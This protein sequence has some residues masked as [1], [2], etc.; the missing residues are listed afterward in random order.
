MTNILD[1]KHPDPAAPA[2]PAAIEFDG[3]AL[4]LDAGALIGPES[5][6]WEARGT[7]T[8]NGR[9]R[10][11]LTLTGFAIV[12]GAVSFWQAS[13]FTLLVIVLGL[14]AWELQERLGK[15]VRVRVDERGVHLD[16]HRYPH[17]ELTSFD[18]HEMADGTAE[19][20][21]ATRRW[22]SAHLRLS[23]GEQ[24]PNDV[25]SLLA[26]HVPEEQHGLSLVDWLIKRS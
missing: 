17:S 1:L 16:G 12:G 14:A 5:L 2:E 13:W 10:H 7:L 22:H 6:E 18:V 3:D 9:Y 8:P 20:S 19:L 21:L 25:R 4:A 24:N 15:P 11:Y 26:R 23:L